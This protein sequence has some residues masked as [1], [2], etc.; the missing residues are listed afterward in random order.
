MLRIWAGVVHG[1]WMRLHAGMAS[2]QTS[3]RR[4]NYW[5]TR[6]R[7]VRQPW[8]RSM[9]DAYAPVAGKVAEVGG[10]LG[11]PVSAGL[12][13]TRDDSGGC[14]QAMAVGLARS[15]VTAR[16]RLGAE[17]KAPLCEDG[18]GGGGAPRADKVVAQ[19]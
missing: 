9:V 5:V 6:A 13:G 17:A 11:G 8:W 14:S 16:W 19:S 7:L 15:V 3:S 12:G 1:L 10:P 18:G 2:R 4:D